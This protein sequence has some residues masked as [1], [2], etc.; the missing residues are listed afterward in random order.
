MLNVQEHT[1]YS[2]QDQ[3]NHGDHIGNQFA[4]IRFFN[5]P[6]HKCHDRAEHTNPSGYP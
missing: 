3:Q 5:R 6:E 4:V 1:H 2:Y